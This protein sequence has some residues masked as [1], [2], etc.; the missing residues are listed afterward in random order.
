MSVRETKPDSGKKYTNVLIDWDPEADVPS[1]TSSAAQKA[2]HERKIEKK[3]HLLETIVLN[4]F[5]VIKTD[6]RKKYQISIKS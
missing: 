2:A 6:Q 5:S 3:E 4:E 1:S